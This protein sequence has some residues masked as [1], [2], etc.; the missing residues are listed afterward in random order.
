MDAEFQVH[1]ENRIADLMQ[2]GLSRDEAKER[3]HRD[4]GSLE[5]AKDECRD[6]RAFEPGDRFLRNLRHA[7]RSLSRSPGYCAAAILTLALGIGA[8]TAIF[9]ALEGV[10]LKPLPYHE[11]DR[12]VIVL[13]YNRSLKYDTEV[14]YPDF[15]DW[16]LDARSFEQIAAFM[17]AG[18]DLTGPG[19]PQHLDGYAVSSDFFST[20]GVKLVTGSS[21]SP[22]SD[23]IG[24]MPAA[25]ISNRL[26][27]ERFHSSP[28]AVGHSIILNGTG[29]TITGVLP[30][31]FRFEN[32]LADIYTPIGRADPLNQRDRT[33]HDVLCVARLRPG[34]D[35]GQARAAM[36]TLQE[37]I[38]ELNP[39]TEKGQS[40]FILPLKQEIVGDV[41]ETLLLLLAAVSLVLL[42][43]CANVANLLLARS[44]VRAR[45]FAV[46]RALG[47]SR[48]QI[49][50]QLITESV[51][52]SCA[53]GLLG[54]AV[55]KLTLIAVLA[56]F[57]GGLPRV[58]NI[59]VNTSV[60][61]FAFG[62]SIAVGIL[63]ALVPALKYG[64]TDVQVGLRE[65]GDGSTANHQRTQSCLVI[66]QIALALV[67]LSG[68]GLLFRS[69]LKLWAVNPGFDTQ[70]IL[71]FQVGLSPSVTQTAASTRAVYEQLTNR[72][73]QI[74]GVEA[75][76]MTALVPLGRTYNSGPFWIG[77]HRPPVS[78]A[79]IPRATYYPIGPDYPQAMQIPLLL[80]RFLQRTDDLH[81]ELVVLVDSQM[82]RSYFPQRDPL[83]Q[84]ITIPHWG[85]QQNVLAR[86]VGVVGHVEQYGMDGSGGENPQIYFSIYQ[87]PDDAL[88]VFRE[89]IN[90]V[91]RTPLSPAAIRP[92]VE[93]AVEAVGTAEPV[94]NIRTMRD[95]VSTSLSRRRFPMIL[96]VAFALS[97][98]LLATVGIYGLISYWTAQRAREIGVRMALGA[99]NW[100]VIRLL[101]GQG[102]R[103][104][105]AGIAMGAL[106]AAMLTRVISSFSRLLYGVRATDWLTFMAVALFLLL[107]ALL[108]SYIPARRAARLDPM[109]VLRHD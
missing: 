100:N 61:L 49:V 76:A 103:L 24:G 64:N 70:H 96:L 29:F 68:A 62:L 27:R 26:W 8:N 36:N 98:L 92:S 80:G 7:F 19:L 67:L 54:L 72:I 30:A 71:T 55:A 59:G 28:A 2:G 65:G 95:L 53:G 102:L 87:L 18:F 3:A 47:A 17:P 79:E 15:L 14:S 86:I 93:N 48:M 21:F 31:S 84:S 66:A 69:M 34:V 45:E 88:P 37:H 33:V 5:L 78:M 42:I 6:E 63:F 43:A 89:E 94:Y 20:L 35:I 73:H 109:A 101:V 105:L 52:L 9:T 99:A 51:L 82:V 4:F 41:G 38:D 81:S 97:A 12:L 25:V 104:A 22:D 60:L 46:R 75:A 77:P 1:M 85:A 32:E 107:A 90:F 106:A 13:L 16:R 83:G 50:R 91:V 11:P 44:A 74:P 23:R 39:T 56:A 57:P 40:A 10:V 108:A 58:E